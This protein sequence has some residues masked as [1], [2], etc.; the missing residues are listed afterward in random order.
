MHIFNEFQSL[1]RRLS[2]L[3]KSIR[4]DSLFTGAVGK[5]KSSAGEASTAAAAP[6][7]ILYVANAILYAANARLNADSS[8]LVS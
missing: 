1:E 4:D 5:S 6:K 2:F 3:K 7:C 8:N